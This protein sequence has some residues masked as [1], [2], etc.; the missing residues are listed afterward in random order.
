MPRD[1]FVAKKRELKVKR[2][3][4]Y[5]YFDQKQNQIDSG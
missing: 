2:G 1:K 3:T 5:G 4:D